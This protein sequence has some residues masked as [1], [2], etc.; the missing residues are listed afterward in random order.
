MPKIIPSLAGAAILTALFLAAV[1]WNR[2]QV[3]VPRADGGVLVVFAD[4]DCHSRMQRAAM[5]AE[6][7]G[8]IV[9]THDFENYPRGT[10][11]H[12]TAPMDYLI[13]GLG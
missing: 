2:A 5:V 8:T 7:P 6:K 10:T 12:T 9:R 1:S 13:A 11:P 3:F 4:G